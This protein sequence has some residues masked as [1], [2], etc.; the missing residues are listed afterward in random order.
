LSNSFFE[1]QLSKL[2]RDKYKT[3]HKGRAVWICCPFHNESTPSL[4]VNVSGN[5]YL[6]RFFC[7]GCKKSGSWNILCSKVQGLTPIENE[8]TIKNEMDFSFKSRR[9]EEYPDIEELNRMIPWPEHKEWRGIPGTTL[10]KY[11]AKVEKGRHDDVYLRFPVM[12][13]KEYVG[14][15]RALG[16]KPK[17]FSD[18]SKEMGYINSPGE[19]ASKALFG[20]NQA[21][22][23]TLR[24]E[25]LWV[26]EGPRDTL[27]VATHGGRVVGLIGSAIGPDKISLIIQLDP[28]F[29][30]SATDPDQAG[31][32]ANEKL[33]EAFKG[34]IPIKRVKFED[35]TDPADL[36]FERIQKIRK[37]AMKIYT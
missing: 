6:G 31:D 10:V 37:L 8:N 26:V 18:G 4:K 9:E 24:K 16:R 20:Y 28:P 1:Q 15:I 33:F 32:T 2:P 23:K 11:D 35:N 17:R 27:N 7:F 14:Y 34:L 25:P 29:I 13:G 12:Y 21:R 3:E 36:T 22:S 19:W 30:I 5:Q